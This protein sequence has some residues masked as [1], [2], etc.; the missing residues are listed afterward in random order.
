MP[1]RETPVV[2]I[3]GDVGAG[4][5]PLRLGELAAQ[6]RRELSGVTPLLLAE[7]CEAP[8]ALVEALAAIEPRR[9][10]V[11]CRADPQRHG[12][13]RARLRQAGVAP[14][15][16]EIVDLRTADGCTEKVA[17]E[18]SATLLS[19]AVARVA[20]ADVEA[21]VRERTSL[22]V[23]GVSRRSLLRG[24]NTSRR[25]VAV[26][27]PDR[28]AKG[29][30]CTACVLACPHGALRREAGRVVVDGDKCSGCGVCVAACR[31][32][33][34]A[35]PGAEVEGLSAATAVL[36]SAVRRNGSAVGV[37][38]ACR[39]AKSVPGVGE[40]WLVLRVPS[41]EMVTAGWLLQ[42][43]GAGVGVR[44]IAC[45]DKDCETRV[46]NLGHFVRDIKA[47]L[48]FSDGGPVFAEAP[49]GQESMPAV[50]VPWGDRIELREPDATMQ[51]LSVLGA[52]G[53]GRTPWRVEGPGCSLGVVRVDRAGCSLCEVCVG[54]CPTGAFAAERNGAGLLHL[55]VDSRRCTGCE[56]CVSSC[57]EAVITL[58]KAVDGAL[59]SKGR[60]VVA[61][62]PAVSCE[63]CGAPLVAGP[64]QA[65][66]RRLGGSHPYLT[67]GSTRICADCWLGGRSVTGSRTSG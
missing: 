40:P 23:G 51:A 41:I 13:L 60:Q 16:T 25:F 26:W 52:L 67:A 55:S 56:A 5:V 20:A 27:L 62:G 38:I 6:L 24:V 45:E 31:S 21:P 37:A 47:R 15:G 59:L 42:L 7:I 64:S 34:F 30:A 58:E 2:V 43:V 63:R 35:L 65:A 53:T 10:V 4:P 61:T 66:L 49:A 14:A 39:H 12:G 48:G 28:C 50:S 11:G 17:L 54:V 1:S 36:V 3:C 8:Q 29:A 46:A 33:A 18:Q 32:T 19:A 22:S 57:P 44:V 9:V